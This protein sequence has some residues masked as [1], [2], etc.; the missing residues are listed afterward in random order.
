MHVLKLI[1]Y[2][3]MDNIQDRTCAAGYGVPDSDGILSVLSNYGILKHIL[4]KELGGTIHLSLYQL[5]WME[6]RRAEK[7]EE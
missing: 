5:E 4:L 6:N 2:V 7:L 3:L 1:V